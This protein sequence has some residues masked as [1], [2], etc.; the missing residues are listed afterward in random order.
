MATICP[1]ITPL[2]EDEYD[3]QLSRVSL[4]AKRIQ[5]DLMDK[6]FAGS[7]STLLVDDVW[8]P[9]HNEP[10][11][12]LMYKDP[13][14]ELHSLIR[15]KPSMV[16]IHVETMVHHMHFAA[17]LHKAGIKAGL[18]ILPETPV[19]NIEQIIHSFDHLLIFSGNLGHFGGTADLNLLGKV[20]EA[21]MHHPDIEIG[22]DG[23]I[24]DHNVATLIQS[25]VDVLNVGG[26]IQKSDEPRQAYEQLV[27][28]CNE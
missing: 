2:N 21:K 23:G 25:G 22:W 7:D 28:L 8:W 5:I 20:R 9:P 6:Q 27:N 18:S 19:E 1:T 16:I 14:A 13:F 10:D 15:L 24:N 3:Q 11:V 4:F 12:H 26:F 17:E